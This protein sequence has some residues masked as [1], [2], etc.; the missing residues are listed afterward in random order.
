M[1]ETQYLAFDAAGRVLSSKQLTDGAPPNPTLYSYSL[2]GA[3]IEQTY[4]SGRA[5][6]NT[7]DNDGDLIQVQ[8]RKAN[9]TLRNYANG[10][11]YTAAGAVAAM[12]LG[13]GKW[14]S[15]EFNS[16]LQPTRIG[17]GGSASD[18]S[19]L[20][21]DYTYGVIVNG[22]LH[23]AKNNGNIQ[24]QT[25]TVPTVGT[26]T[27]FMAVQTY[28]YDALNRIDEAK[29]VI[30][31]TEIWKQDYRSTVSATGTSSRR[32]RRRSRGTASTTRRRR[33]ESYAMWTGR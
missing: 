9:D 22:Q 11:T 30:G 25:T 15:T 24:S 3:L 2:S 26:S 28:N 33:I 31:S 7:L 5:V 13:N 6:R 21:L 19:L 10:F 23:T 18:Q 27:G 29:E 32:T 14:E 4:P 1:S 8:S 16:R 12:R 20:K 17:L